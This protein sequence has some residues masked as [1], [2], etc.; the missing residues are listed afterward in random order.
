[1][2]V[3]KLL[4]KL[5][6]V[7]R[8][9]ESPAQL[10]WGF[11]LGMIIGLTPFWNLHNLLVFFLITIFNVNIAMATLSFAV[12][13]LFAYL[14]DPLFHNLGYA[15]LVNIESLRPLWIFTSTT[16]VLA[17]ANLN[18]TVVLGSLVVSL[19]LLLPMFFFT[20]WWVRLYR[21]K[22]DVHVQKFK[23]VQLIKGSKLFGLYQK[24]SQLGE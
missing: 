1:M 4:S 8:S 15:L 18:N 16:P 2:F 10:A 9:N 22:V 24:I 21:D 19:V 11:V 3:I 20:K 14:L 13:T 5:I 6:K 17:W 12:F 7:L 23:I